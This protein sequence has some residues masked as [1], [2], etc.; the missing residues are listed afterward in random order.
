VQNYETIFGRL[1]DEASKKT[2]LDTFRLRLSADPSYMHDYGVRADEQ[3]FENFLNLEE[4][5]SFADV[6]GFDGDTT[7]KLLQRYPGY[8]KVHFFEPSVQNLDKAKRR[9]GSYQV[10]SYYHN[11]VSNYAGEAML[12]GEA[13]PTCAFSDK[14]EER[15]EVNTLDNLVADSIDFIKMDIEGFELKAI[16]GARRHIADSRTKL[17]IAAY[18]KPGDIRCICDFVLALRPQAKVYLRHYT[19]GVSESILFFV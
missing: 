4:G 13:G 18:H 5:V 16:E 15:V 6:G 11:G 12:S 10:V 3:Y 14:G 19:E 1:A 17:A 8:S 2:M 9:L 7:E